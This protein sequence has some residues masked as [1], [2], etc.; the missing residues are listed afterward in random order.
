MFIEYV[1]VKRL[2]LVTTVTTDTDSRATNTGEGIGCI[3]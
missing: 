1:H 3:W 2:T